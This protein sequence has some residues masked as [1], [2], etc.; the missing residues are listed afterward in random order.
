LESISPF[1]FFSPKQTGSLS[2][3]ICPQ[4]EQSGSGQSY[5]S[6]FT[7]RRRSPGQL[8]NDILLGDTA[9]K[10]ASSSS[11]KANAPRRILLLAAG[12]LCLLYSAALVTSFTRNR[13][14]ETK[15]RQAAAGIAPVEATGL[16]VASL[17]SLQRLETLRQSLDTL[18]EYDR[19]GA[20]WSYRSG[21]YIGNTLLPDVRKLY[22]ENFRRLLL[23]QTQNVLLGLL[24]GL[25]AA[26]GPSYG[27]TYDSLKAYLISTSNHDKSTRAFL[28]PVLLNRWS[29]NRT[30][31]AERSQLAQKQFDFYSS[32]LAEENPFSSGNDAAAVT[33]ARHYLAKFAGFERV[34]QAM[35]ADAAKNNPSFTFNKRFPGSAE[36]V[37]DTVEIAGPFTKPA[38]DFY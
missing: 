25:P 33:R 26:P 4:S 16:T 13:A 35:L 34:Y 18:T 19:K 1:T 28:S 38:W 9:A 32:E 31:E 3:R 20:P 5:R 21:L 30:V 17:D 6:H 10:G 2:S 23:G 24:R 15:V 11:I 8:F 7:D 29:A 22:F 37:V 12:I 27:P 36:T 14:L